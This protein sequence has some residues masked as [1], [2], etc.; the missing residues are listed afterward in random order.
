M[1]SPFD[2]IKSFSNKKEIWG[3]ETDGK[4]YVPFVVNR[5]L[6]FMQDCV[7]Y[8]N[9][10]NQ[11]HE[12][13]EKAQHDFYFN[14]IPKGRRYAEWIKAEECDADVRLVSE[15]Y[16]INNRMAKKYVEMLS[17]DQLLIIREKMNRGGNYER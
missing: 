15:Y 12:L 4:D 14:A 10:M 2:F 7:H 9:I 3:V 6:S 1:A 8:S 13:P 5:G 17:G 11:Y 16:C